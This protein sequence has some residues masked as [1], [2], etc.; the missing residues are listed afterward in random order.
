MRQLYKKHNLYVQNVVPKENLLVWNL[1]D[2]WEPLCK[3]LD[4]P[5]PQGIVS[6]FIFVR[7]SEMINA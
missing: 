3:F 7:N 5:I 2:G 4:K 1:K 6:I